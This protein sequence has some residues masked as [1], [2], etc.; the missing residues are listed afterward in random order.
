MYK[1]LSKIKNIKI[2]YIANSIDKDDFIWFLDGFRNK[3]NAIAIL[4]K[5]NIKH[6]V[7]VG[8]LIVSKLYIDLVKKIDHLINL[9]IQI[10]NCEIKSIETIYDFVVN[11][12]FPFESSI[13]IH[14]DL[15]F[16]LSNVDNNQKV[17]ISKEIISKINGFYI[18]NPTQKINISRINN[19]LTFT[20]NDSYNREIQQSEASIDDIEG[21]IKIFNIYS[22]EKIKIAKQIKINVINN[23]ILNY[24]NGF[25]IDF[26]DYESDIIQYSPDS[27]E[28]CIQFTNTKSGKNIII[29]PIV[30]DPETGLIIEAGKGMGQIRLI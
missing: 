26:E 30:F 16:I 9:N 19:Q 22:H 15:T 7:K 18:V 8:V 1:T 24:L 17:I 13:N 10:E 2:R 28:I 3:N 4:K 11:N 5:L 12:H 21:I 29:Y 25:S 6:N 27:D 20:F 14:G 23:L